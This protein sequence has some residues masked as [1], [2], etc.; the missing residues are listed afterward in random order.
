[1]SVH[2]RVIV[3]GHYLSLGHRSCHRGLA[4]RLLEVGGGHIAAQT[5]RR[6]LVD[7]IPALRGFSGFCLHD[8]VQPAAVRVDDRG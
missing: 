4:S 3:T 8:V 2:R 1:M 6:H 5:T 7:P